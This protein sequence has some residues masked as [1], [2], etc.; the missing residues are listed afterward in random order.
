MRRQQRHQQPLACRPDGRRARPSAPVSAG[1]VPGGEAGRHLALGQAVAG[2]RALEQLQRHGRGAGAGGARARDGP[3]PTRP[4]R[5]DAPTS[6]SGHGT[7]GGT[8]RL[9]DRLGGIAAPRPPRRGAAG[10]ASQGGSASSRLADEADQL[11]LRRRRE[12]AGQRLQPVAGQH[13]LLQQR[14][15]AEGGRQRARSGCRSGSAS[16]A[17]RGSASA[18]TS[19]DAAAAE[20]DLA[21]RR[22]VAEHRRQAREAVAGAEQHAQAVQAAEIVRQVGRA[23]PG[24]GPAPP[25]CRPGRR[26]RAEIPSARRAAAAPARR[27]DHRAAGRRGLRSGPSLSPA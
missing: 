26:P 8:G 12:A 22:A 15:L 1:C 4:R 17:A 21:Q 7:R 16:A 3:G 5:A 27:R 20:A 18:G 23:R 19:P 24:R 14:P 6:R 13:Q 11:E 2:H 25:A 10:R 9:G